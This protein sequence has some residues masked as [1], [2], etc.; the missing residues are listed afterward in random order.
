M[1]E[2]GYHDWANTVPVCSN[3]P[4]T[5]QMKGANETQWTPL[6]HQL[7]FLKVEC[8]ELLEVSKHTVNN[9]SYTQS[10][11]VLRVSACLPME[12]NWRQK[13][14]FFDGSKQAKFARHQKMI[15]D[16]WLATAFEG[17]G[18]QYERHYLLVQWHQAWT[19]T[20]QWCHQQMM[21]FGCFN[22]V[23]RRK[24]RMKTFPGVTVSTNHHWPE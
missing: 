21:V 14:D 12:K 24:K 15:D 2:L 23:G 16:R 3:A 17:P 19:R 9:W 20:L 11:K 8:Q 18:H 6:C 13:R 10:P 5:R 4:R 22:S 7:H 1:K